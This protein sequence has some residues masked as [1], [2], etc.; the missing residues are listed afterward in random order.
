MKSFDDGSFTVKD[1]TEFDELKKVL[2]GACVELIGE[3]CNDDGELVC[4]MRNLWWSVSHE[5]QIT[6]DAERREWV[7]LKRNS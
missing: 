6:T 3:Y 1:L 2:K 4:S 7:M 5:E